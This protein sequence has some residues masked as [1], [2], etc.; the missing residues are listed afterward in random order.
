MFRK[1]I[2][3]R[4]ITRVIISFKEKIIF[5]SLGEN[6]AG[7]QMEKATMR[8]PWDVWRSFLK[9]FRDRLSV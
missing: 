1:S 8:Y 3:H 2:C 4:R 6:L 7:G 9:I 5:L